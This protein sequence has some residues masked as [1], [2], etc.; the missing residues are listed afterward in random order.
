MLIKKY[1]KNKLEKIYLATA[2]IILVISGMAF[3]FVNKETKSNIESAKQSELNLVQETTKRNEIKN[4]NN[5]FNSIEKEKTQFETHFVQR[6]DVVSYL[7]SLEALAK[8]IGTKGEVLSINLSD[9]KSNLLVEMSDE[10]TF[11]N[12]YKFITL[13]E[14]APFEMEIT[15]IDLNRSNSEEKKTT[16]LWQ[17]L[18]KFKLVSFI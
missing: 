5:Y 6:S 16:V 18:I 2:V 14:N 1:M 9:D 3:F 8:D 12:V 15:Y 7:N 4:L 10:G 11:P 17:A 13:L